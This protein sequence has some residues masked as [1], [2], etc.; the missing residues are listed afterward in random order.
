MKFTKTAW[1]GTLITKKLL[2]LGDLVPQTPYQVSVP[3]NYYSPHFIIEHGLCGNGSMLAKE[4]SCMLIWNVC[5]KYAPKRLVSDYFISQKSFSFWGT[6]SPRPLTSFILQ[7]NLIFPSHQII[8]NDFSWMWGKW[9]LKTILLVIS[10]NCFK[11]GPKWMVSSLIFQEFSGEGLTETPSQTPPP[12]F[13]EL[14]PRFGLR[15]QFSG[16]SGPRFRLRP[17]YSDA[18][19]PRFWLRPQLSIGDLGLAPKVNFWIRQW[20][21][22]IYY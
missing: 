13:L 11:Y 21:S 15:P 10:N 8:T 20:P 7:Q 5:S 3:Q 14:R 6:K 2:L 22:H 17:R 1:I 9:A 19:R 16:A 4:F 18:S 12:L